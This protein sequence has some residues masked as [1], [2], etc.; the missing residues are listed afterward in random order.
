MEKSCSLLRVIPFALLVVAVAFTR[1]PASATIHHD[2]HGLSLHASARDTVDG[3][4]MSG[5]RPPGGG[6][7]HLPADAAAHAWASR[8]WWYVVGQLTDAAGH[9]YGFETTVSKVGDLRKVIPGD[10]YNVAFHTDISITDDAT[11]RFYQEMSFIGPQGASLSAKE[12]NVHAGHARLT[13]LGGL[14]YR[15]Q[16]SVPGAAS[17]ITVVS[18]RPALLVGGGLVPWGDGYSYYYSLTNMRATGTLTIGGRRIAVQGEAWLDHQWGNWTALGVQTPDVQHWEWMGMRLSDGLSINM[19]SQQTAHGVRGGASALLPDNRQRPVIRGVTMTA[20]SR[21]RSPTTHALYPMDWRVRIPS[22]HLA[23]TVHATVKDQ[24]LVDNFE[25]YGY[26]LSYWEGLCIVA[27]THDG[28]R[29]TGT[30]YTELIGYSTPAG[31]STV[32]K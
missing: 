28:H 26:R 12:L 20:L 4:T 10:P 8:E 27:G 24:E 32:P 19:V 22:L 1:A 18:T 31:A 7:I 2:T 9:T 30:T 16:G 3:P 15:V 6:H 5:A 11:H 13:S 17:D 21:W 29:V 23:V 25:V 14:R